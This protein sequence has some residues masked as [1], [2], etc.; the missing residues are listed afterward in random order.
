MEARLTILT[1]TYNR[2]ST[3]PRL[4]ESIVANCPPYSVHWVV[5]D[6]GSTDESRKWVESLTNHQSIHITYISQ[7]NSGKHKAVQRGLEY[8]A[9]P[10]CFIMDSD[11]WFTPNAFE[12][13]HSW[14]DWLETNPSVGGVVGL[15]QD[16]GGRVIGTRFPEDDIVCTYQELHRRYKIRGDKKRLIRTQLLRDAVPIPDFPGPIRVPPSLL[17]RRIG[18]KAPMIH[19]NQVI[20]NVEYRADGITHN[21]LSISTRS[22]VASCYYYDEARKYDAKYPWEFVRYAINYERYRFHALRSLRGD[23][24][25][26]SC[27][28]GLLGYLF[29]LRDRAEMRRERVKGVL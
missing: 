3:L 8:V 13:I 16:A 26:L 21:L 19:K 17:W 23:I 29:Y 27:V 14:I 20:T 18:R 12:I 28:Y 1:P 7:E 10:Y 5:V 24:P 9:T 15:C 4:Y 11:D 6:D 2:C 22:A 25:K